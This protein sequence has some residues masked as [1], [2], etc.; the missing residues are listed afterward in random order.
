MA[1]LNGMKGQ[2]S[3]YEPAFAMRVAL[4]LEREKNQ[5]LIIST[6]EISTLPRAVKQFV[7]DYSNGAVSA[8][9][10]APVMEQ[11]ALGAQDSRMQM[12]VGV[13]MAASERLRR[14]EK[15][16]CMRGTSCRFAH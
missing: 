12:Q 5:K 3:S 9:Q 15:G 10:L 16:T 7:A 4:L 11:V 1:S 2:L 13:L 8:R 14:L 6:K